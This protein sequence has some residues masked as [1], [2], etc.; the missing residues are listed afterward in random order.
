[1]LFRHGVP[2]RCLPNQIPYRAQALALHAAGCRSLLVTSSVGV[3]DP[4]LPLDVPLLLTDLLTLDNRLPDGSACSLYPEPSDGQGHL[5]IEDALF[6]PALT[7]AT[8]AIAAKAGHP[9]QG[10]AV[11]GYVGGPRSKTAAEN[12]MWARLG[13]Q[14]NSMTVGPEV[15]LAAEAGISVAGLGVGHKVSRAGV[16]ERLDR[17]SI[18]RSLETGRAIIDAVV[19]AWLDRVEPV[20]FGNQIYRYPN[21]DA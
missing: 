18:D 11:F 21:P 16:H 9:V 7:E 17:E 8:A 6:S 20:P 12:E 3:L 14:V 2:H 5:V 10:R 19:A 13:A 1:V 15:V 4:A